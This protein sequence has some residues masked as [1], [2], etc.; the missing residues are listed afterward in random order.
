MWKHI[1]LSDETVKTMIGQKDIT[2]A[3]NIPYKIYGK[4]SCKSGWKKMKRKNRIFFRSEKEAIKNG[5]RPCGSC[6]RESFLVWK[7]KD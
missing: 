4:L 3:G 7:R 5:Y 6:M 1:N 2:F